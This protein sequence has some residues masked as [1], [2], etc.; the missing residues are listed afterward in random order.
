MPVPAVIAKSA[1]R[2]IACDL[3]SAADLQALSTGVSWWY[4]WGGKLG[5]SGATMDYVPM[6]WG[7]GSSVTA[8]QANLLA[9]PGINYLLLM[10]Q[11]N[12]TDQANL[13]PGDAAALWP[14]YEAL[15]KATGVKL[16]G[17]AIT[18]GTLAGYSDPVVWMDAFIAAYQAANAGAPPAAF[19][20]TQ[21]GSRRASGRRFSSGWRKV[22]A[23]LFT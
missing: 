9:N 16:V 1:K 22:G 4:N 17:P 13:G 8:M 20:R 12:L 14:Q 23:P 18:W 6:L 2:G 11:P 10:N 19:L 3:A 15:A 5:V 7:K 21:H